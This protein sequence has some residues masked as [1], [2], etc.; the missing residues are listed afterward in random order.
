MEDKNNMLIECRACGELI[1]KNAKS[2]PV[3]GEPYESKDGEK[4]LA[5]LH[6][7]AT[8]LSILIAVGTDNKI[9]L[10]LPVII[11]VEYILTVAIIKAIRGE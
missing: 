6:I 11:W 9:F 7:G 4:I 5:I 2:C 8:F 3:C 1:S 10:W